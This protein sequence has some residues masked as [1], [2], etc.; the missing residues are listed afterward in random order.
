MLIYTAGPYTGNIDENI[1]AAARVAA[2]LWDMGHAVICPH[3]NTAHF[4]DRCKNADYHDFLFGDYNIISRVDA[5]VMLPGWRESKGA[6]KER[7]YALD[8]GVPVWEYPEVPLPHPT[9]LFCPR[10]VQAFRE[11]V[12]RMY[13]VHLDKNADYSPANIMA[14][15]ELGLA[16]RLWDKI[17]RLMNLLGFRFTVSNPRYVAP[18]EPKGESIDDTLLDAAVYA[19]IGLLLRRRVWGR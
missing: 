9:E 2:E 10:Q 3:A 4:E 15:G 16:T 13:R 6:C 1:E 12:M 5:L 17:A 18:Q 8:L 7:Q 19:V 14:T 11:T